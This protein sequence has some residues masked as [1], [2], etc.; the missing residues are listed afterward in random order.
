MSLNEKLKINQ[1]D[2]I[3]INFL[4]NDKIDNKISL[5]R[6]KEN[7]NIKG[8]IF[9]VSY[10][11]DKMLEDNDNK[12]ISKLLNNFNS[13][14]KIKIDKT[15]LDKISFLN[16]TNGSITLKK[17]G[18]VNLNLVSNFSDNKELKF[19]I[20]TNDNNEK[21]TTLFSGNAKPL[22]KRYK[23]IKGFEEGS[24]DFY[25]TKKDTASSSKLKIYDFKLNELPALTKILTLASLTGYC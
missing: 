23:F 2:K 6:N 9:D 1:I 25:S 13:T 21:I 5:S 8:K 10:L 19:T 14:I 12:S 3:K 24:L 22:V 15:H 20:N 11:L 18:I 17:G 7:Y 4:N 16:N